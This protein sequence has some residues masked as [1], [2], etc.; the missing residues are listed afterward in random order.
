MLGTCLFRMIFSPERAR[1]TDVLGRNLRCLDPPDW[2]LRL[3]RGGGVTITTLFD[4]LGRMFVLD[5]LCLV[6]E[7]LDGVETGTRSMISPSTLACDVSGG[8]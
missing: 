3:L 2:V 4:D 5:W 1:D 8:A 6:S 7:D